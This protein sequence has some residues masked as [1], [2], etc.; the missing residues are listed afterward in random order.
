ML[1]ALLG[2]LHAPQ[3]AVQHK[4]AG[5]QHLLFVPSSVAQYLLGEHRC[6][7]QRQ[8]AFDGRSLVSQLMHV[9]ALMLCRCGGVSGQSEQGLLGL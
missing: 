8:D 4:V 7:L 3:A 2:E 1:H 6:H 9:S 5:Q